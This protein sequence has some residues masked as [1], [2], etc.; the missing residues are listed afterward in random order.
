M[1]RKKINV[2][3]SAWFGTRNIGDEAILISE[4]T[5]I[6]RALP[7]ANITVFSQK[8][9]D[10]NIERLDV[11][12]VSNR[13]S[14]F[15]GIVQA[16]KSTDIFIFGGGGLIQD[17]S[18]IFNILCQIY[19]IWLATIF[20]KTT[21]FFGLGVGPVK[22]FANRLLLKTLNNKNIRHITVRDEVSRIT[23]GKCSRGLLEKTSVTMD[24]VINFPL[25]ETSN[26]NRETRNIGIA[27]KDWFINYPFVSS[28]MAIRIN[29][30]FGIKQ[31]K[32]VRFTLK[33]A[34]LID[35]LCEE[36][37]R[38]H[39]IP[40][41]GIRDEGFQKEILELCGNSPTIE[42]WSPCVYDTV[43]LIDKMD[44]VIGMR[45]HSLIL[46]AVLGKKIVSLNYS[47]K[48]RVFMDM[49]SLKDNQ[50]DL[51]FDLDKIIEL[52]NREFSFEGVSYSERLEKLQDYERLNSKFFVETVSDLP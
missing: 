50:F 41:E 49:L 15:F 7:D 48:V 22:F 24:T 14:N 12:T 39:L 44:L 3:I 13:F 16:I 52:I 25:H 2:L 21:F 26:N 17:D 36:G 20:G 34:S 30:L 18:S 4:V 35:S 8:F 19:K 33:I 31:R 38:V 5:S 23:L 10:A 42:K 28:N 46:A 37:Y 43:A 29:K 11:K 27:L 40:M 6:R 47:G 1:R 45:L 9:N 32:R 51:D